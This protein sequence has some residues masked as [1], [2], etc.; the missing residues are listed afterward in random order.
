MPCARISKSMI[1]RPV[2]VEYADMVGSF[3]YTAPSRQSLPPKA[4][5]K[6]QLPSFLPA[7]HARK[8]NLQG[9]GEI[10]TRP[11][12]APICA[13]SKSGEREMVC[14][15]TAAKEVQWTATSGK[16]ALANF[17]FKHDCEQNDL[18]SKYWGRARKNK[19]NH[20]DHADRMYKL[21]TTDRTWG[22]RHLF[23]MRWIVDILKLSRQ[24]ARSQEATV[25]MNKNNRE[26]D[27]DR[28][29]ELIIQ[30]VNYQGMARKIIEGNLRRR[31]GIKM[32]KL[33]YVLGWQ[34]ILQD[35]TDRIEDG[36]FRPHISY[37]YVSKTFKGAGRTRIIKDNSPTQRCQRQESSGSCIK[38][39]GCIRPDPFFGSPPISLENL[40]LGRFSPP[41]QINDCALGAQPG[42]V[43]NIV[44]RARK[45]QQQEKNQDYM[46]AMDD[47]EHA[48]LRLAPCG[49]LFWAFNLAGNVSNSDATIYPPILA[50]CQ[51][52]PIEHPT[53]TSNYAPLVMSTF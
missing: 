38:A 30:V 22:P 35:Q 10:A 26:D 34:E 14:H 42:Q 29:C 43:Y 31:L 9:S 6:L 39:L 13:K 37:F 17:N 40:R 33:V 25:D 20:Q 44:A 41:L 2:A 27:L 48:P 19:N 18:T 23:Q 36:Y 51:P 46:D 7:R 53:P 8:S 21:G 49:L 24:G 4:A 3:A 5:R 12:L 1:S 11:V 16:G 28:M 45:T 52:R 50:S 47:C 32:A 15:L